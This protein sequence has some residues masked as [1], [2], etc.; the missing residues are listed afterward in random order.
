[1]VS[2]LYVIALEAIVCGL[3]LNRTLYSK[4]GYMWHLSLYVLIKSVVCTCVVSQGALQLVTP[5]CIL[6]SLIYALVCF[7][8]S[9]K[10]KLAVVFC[11]VL[12]LGAS[13]L[14]KF[15]MLYGFGLTQDYSATPDILATKIV[16]CISILFFCIFTIICTNL[17][18][19]VRVVI[20]FGITLVSLLLM[21][22]IALIYTYMHMLIPQRF[23]SLYSVFAL[24]FLLPSIASLYFGE[25]ITFSRK[26]R[27]F[28]E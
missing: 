4:T 22:F 27:Y 11:G 20:T 2:V 1:M 7:R 28:R 17:L 14:I 25:S 6:F 9:I 19:G 18:C 24:F 16:I 21:I 15:T 26:D 23:N 3:M 10:R 13:N 8:D 5:L 12:C